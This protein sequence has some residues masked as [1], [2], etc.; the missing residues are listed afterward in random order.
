MSS[1][2]SRK[3]SNVTIVETGL[4]GRP[5]TGFSAADAEHRRAPWT[6]R[7][8]IEMDLRARIGEDLLDEIVLPCRDAAGN[9]ESIGFKALL[10]RRFQFRRS[11]GRIAE[12]DGLAACKPHLR[13]ERNA[14]SIA[15]FEWA[16]S[17]IRADDLVAGGKNRDTRPPGDAHL[18]LAHLAT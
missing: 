16:G 10:D 9:H 5:K 4:P 2:G 6:D 17:G 13:R 8:T 7:N 12:F 15:Y 14:V 18:R 3:S 1:V 11:I